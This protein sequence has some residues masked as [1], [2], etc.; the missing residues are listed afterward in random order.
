MAGLYN[1]VVIVG[2]L[3]QDVELKYTKGGTAVANLSV[4]T[5]RRVKS[6]EKWE[7]KAVWLRVVVWGKTAENTEKYC[8]K[9][10]KVLVE[11]EL[12]I[13]E[14]KDKEGRER[15]DVQIQASQVLFMD[16]KGSGGGGG[17]E[18]SREEPPFVDDSDIP[19]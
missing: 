9:G 4:C 13:N 15:K 1:R 6:G 5:E 10:S 11:G 14:W 7:N 18:S 12:D 3:G 16:S 8:G 2:R 19:F 17:G